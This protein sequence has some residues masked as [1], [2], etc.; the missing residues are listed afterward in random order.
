LTGCD[1]S[2]HTYTLTFQLKNHEKQVQCGDTIS[3]HDDKWSINQFQFFIHQV[4]VQTKE[5]TWH[6]LNFET[7]P[8]STS[9]VALL[10]GD[11]STPQNWTINL[12]SQV[13]LESVKQLQFY[14]GV[15]F[16]LNHQNPITQAS[17][18]NQ[19]DMF[20]VWQTG[21][22]FLRWEMQSSK[23]SFIYHLGSTGCTSTASV[24]APSQECKNPNRSLIT[25]DTHSLT[26]PIH[27]ELD[28]FLQN[29][30]LSQNINCKSMPDNDTCSTLLQRTGIDGNQQLFNMH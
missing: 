20:W 7:G 22:K 12:T 5:G 16:E 14:L 18:L 10:G 17:P 23:H 9:K 25:L 27:I 21:H 19:S 15:P 29:I 3:I 28:V 11:C 26:Q 30:D 6:P 24:R 13:A 4:T 8:Q 2:A 1:S